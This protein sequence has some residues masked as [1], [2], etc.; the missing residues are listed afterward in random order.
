M[1][2]ES[3]PIYQ[4]LRLPLIEEKNVQVLVKRLDLLHPVVQGN[5]HYKLLYNIQAAKESGHSCLLTFGGAY[6]N[7][8]HATALSAAQNGLNSIGMI[9]GEIPKPLNPTLADAKT[10]G[11]ELYPMSRTSY[12]EK[13]D[14]EILEKLK[15]KF[16]DVYIIPEGG[17]NALAIKGSREILEPDDKEMDIVTVP[18]GTGGTFAGLLASASSNQQVLGFSALKG[19]FIHQE[20]S[21]LLEAH[22]ISPFCS[23]QIHAAYHFGGY[24]KFNPELIQFIKEIKKASGIPLEPLYT[25]KMLFGLLDLIRQDT[26]PRGT[27]ILAI[28]TGGLQ[29]LRGFNQRFHTDL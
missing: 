16:G 1:K 21:S 19:S 8:I 5:K 23:W 11:M 28:H 12:R 25:G 29:G 4:D 14:P 27:R 24:A 26:F 18:V 2:K 22:Q 20:I 10:Q 13:N 9:R 6:S 17:T 15:L 7:H 3:L